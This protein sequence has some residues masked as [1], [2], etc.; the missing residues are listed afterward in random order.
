MNKVDSSRVNRGFFVWPETFR[1]MFFMIQR[2]YD[3]CITVM[4]G[5]RNAGG[6]GVY[7]NSG[8]DSDPDPAVL[9]RRRTR[10]DVFI[11]SATAAAAVFNRFSVPHSEFPT[12]P[13]P[14]RSPRPTCTGKF[15]K[16]EKPVI[17]T[18]VITVKSAVL[19]LHAARVYTR[20][21]L[22][23][24]KKKKKMSTINGKTASVCAEPDG[25]N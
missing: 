10:T 3:Y 7:R 22:L 14:R 25:R 15:M 16:I 5:D 6:A 1:S 18:D 19:I 21:L 12:L 23:D 2:I 11:E 13:I 4:D 20:P 8:F 24:A 17:T 9:R